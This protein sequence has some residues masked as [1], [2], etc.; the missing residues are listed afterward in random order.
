M[1]ITE[2]HEFKLKIKFIGLAA[3]WLAYKHQEIPSNILEYE[4]R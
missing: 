1:N 2:T 3:Q 4:N